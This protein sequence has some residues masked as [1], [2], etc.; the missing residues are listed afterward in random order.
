MVYDTHKSNEK[1]AALCTSLYTYKKIR[2][3]LVPFLRR[4]LDHK[5]IVVEIIVCFIKSIRACEH[6]DTHNLGKLLYR[7]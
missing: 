3:R 2:K 5:Y 7:K 1:N 4:I 6:R